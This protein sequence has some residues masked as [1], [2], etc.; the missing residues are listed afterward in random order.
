MS[1]KESSCLNSDDNLCLCFRSM[2]KILSTHL[3]SFIEMGH[4]ALLLVPAD[5]TLSWL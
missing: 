1:L 5:L 3:M 2:T 4:L